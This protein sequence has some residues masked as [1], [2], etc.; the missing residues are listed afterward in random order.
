MRRTRTVYAGPRDS[1]DIAYVDD[2]DIDFGRMYRFRI[3]KTL[4]G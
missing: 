3:S 1:A 2:R 4:G